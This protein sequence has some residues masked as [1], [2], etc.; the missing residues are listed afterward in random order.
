MKELQQLISESK[1][2]WTKFLISF[3]LGGCSP[4]RPRFDFLP[5]DFL[6]FAKVDY[7]E[8][9]DRGLVNSLTNLKRAID[10]KI[11]ELLLIFGIDIKGNEAQI[12]NF[13]K[14]FDSSDISFKKLKLI[15]FLRFAPA[16]VIAKV[17]NVRNRL[18]H[19]YYKPKIGDVK[20]GLDIAELFINSI[21]S[22]IRIIESEISLSNTSRLKNGIGISYNVWEKA[23]EVFH[24]K[25]NS[26]KVIQIELDSPKK[27]LSIYSDN[28]QFYYLIRLMNSKKSEMDIKKT[29]YLL[30]K[31]L[32]KDIP[33][34][35][36]NFS[37]KSAH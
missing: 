23:F 21:E 14:G 32:N 9:D 13:I 2:D 12:N 18:E 8:G 28:L 20:E 5:S 25:R 3:E 7:S 27:H 36:I 4:D 26:E 30:L 6:S 1:I 35:H 29:L 33:E 37:I 31:S 34:K 16:S 15:N 22:K 11:D 24:I 17:R 19:R 10:C